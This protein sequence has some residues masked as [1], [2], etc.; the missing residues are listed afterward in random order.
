MAGSKIR[1]KQSSF[2]ASEMNTTVADFYDNI[3]EYYDDMTHFHGRLQREKQIIEKWVKRYRF[4][5]VLDAACGSGVHTIILNQL[6]VSAV[7][8][9][10]SHEMIKKAR[11]NAARMSLKALFLQSALQD[12]DIK[13]EPKYDAVLFLG[14]S[15]P[16]I[17]SKTELIEIFIALRKLLFSKGKLLIQLLNYD[18]IMSIKNRIV[19]INRIQNQEYIRFYDFL[20]GGI[21]F[22]VLHVN[23]DYSPCKY[24]IEYTDLY[25]YVKKDLVTYIQKS[26]YRILDV[27]GSMNFDP[28]DENESKDLVILAEKQ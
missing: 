5:R 18:R 25:P 17:E 22:N 8:V 13:S 2:E 19:S 21:R 14:N 23:W 26:G 4:K 1:A 24:S 6:G 28:Y 16:H 3:S 9:D 27:F 7:G 20:L 12:L 11:E 15:V 10:I